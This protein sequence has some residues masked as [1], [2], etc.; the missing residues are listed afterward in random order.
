MR[1]YR[2]KINQIPN[3]AIEPAVPNTVGNNRTRPIMV[4]VT[5]NESDV[6]KKTRR[7][8]MRQYRKKK[9]QIPNVAVEPVVPGTVGKNHIGDVIMNESDV[10]KRKRREY[11]RRYREKKKQIPNVAIKPV[12]PNTV[13]N[14]HINCPLSSSG[15]NTN[16]NSMMNSNGAELLTNSQDM[17]ISYSPVRGGEQGVSND[18]PCSTFK[19]N[20]FALKK[21]DEL[22]KNNTF[23]HVCSL[24]SRLWF[25]Q[26]LTSPLPVHEQTLTTN[27]PDFSVN[28]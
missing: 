12:V 6:R 20:K 9:S 23:G 19:S 16:G 1:Q 4:N 5:R 15:V 27:F 10:Q 7:E 21:F 17:N 11:M 8:Y 24:C 28:S 3:V 18:S 22:F 25:L 26:D 13:G 2:V 14:N